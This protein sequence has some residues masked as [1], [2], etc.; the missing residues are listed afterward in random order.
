MFEGSCELHLCVN[1]V[2]S[3]VTLLSITYILCV[4][5]CAH[6]RAPITEMEQS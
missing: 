3:L 5:V 1:G 6:A 2:T 4:C